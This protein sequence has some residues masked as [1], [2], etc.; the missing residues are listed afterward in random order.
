M[1]HRL[2]VRQR[3]LLGQPVREPALLALGLTALGIL[4]LLAACYVAAYLVASFGFGWFAFVGVAA[5]LVPLRLRRHVDAPPP[6]GRIRWMRRLRGTGKVLLTLTLA[7]W[8]GLIAWS[9]LTPG[10]PMPPRAEPGTV[11]VMTWNILHGSDDGPPW[12]QQNWP[13]RKHALAAASGEAQPDIL[14]VQEARPEQVAFLEKTLPGHKR[15]GVGRDDG[16]DAGEHCAIYFCRD[17]FE[18][19]DSD[20]FWLEEPTDQPAASGRWAKRTCTWVRLRQR[21]GGRILCVYNTHLPGRTAALVRGQSRLSAARIVL[22]HIKMGDPSDAVVLVADFNAGPD[23]PSRRL[24]A[25]I[26]LRETAELAGNQ[27]APPT[28]QF[29]GVRMGSLDGILV[30]PEWRVKR[31][32]VVDVKP[33]GVFPSDHFGVLADLMLP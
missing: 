18:A 7:A 28:Y 12:Q 15:V 10:G 30:G 32:T 8:L 14:G 21:D 26:G 9:E 4:L 11:R 24:F 23:A 19:I 17:R 2:L 16:R 5:L 22:D 25:E 3:I 33:D 20:T 29:Y 6:T 27:T 13:A 31:H 1:I